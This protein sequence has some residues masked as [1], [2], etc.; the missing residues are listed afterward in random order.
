V[1]VSV[2]CGVGVGGSGV[3]VGGSGVELGVT[4]EVVVLVLRAVMLGLGEG[5]GVL[6]AVCRPVVSRGLSGVGDVTNVGFPDP[7]AAV[8]GGAL[9]AETIIYAGTAHSTPTRA[10]TLMS[11]RRGRTRWR[12]GGVLAASGGSA[13]DASAF[14]ARV[15]GAGAKVDL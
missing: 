10:S 3:T 9:R 12:T 13:S 8:F 7:L 4:V 2:G 15:S 5:V 6:V 1:G 11:A 14:S